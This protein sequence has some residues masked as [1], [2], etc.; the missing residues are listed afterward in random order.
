MKIIHAYEEEEIKNY[1]IG[2]LISFEDKP[3]MIW[4]IC[5]ELDGFILRKFDGGMYRGHS[6]YNNTL[7]ACLD[8]ARSWDGSIVKHY[9]NLEYELQIVKK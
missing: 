1:Q 3:D 6:G 4:T 2:D 5:K 7:E 9:S 8:E